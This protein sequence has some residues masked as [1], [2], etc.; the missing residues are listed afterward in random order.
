[1]PSWT[2]TEKLTP[3]QAE[4]LSKA[5]Q[6]EKTTNGSLEASAKPKKRNKYNAVKTEY[7]G[8]IYDSKGEANYAAELDMKQRAGLIQGWARQVEFVLAGGVKTK[9]D[10]I[11][12]HTDGTY[13]VVDFKGVLTQESKNKYKQVKAIHGIEVEI[14][15]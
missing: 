3:K 6:R 15:K 5:L 9:V 12:F 11:I 1:M 14:A 7:K 13:D 2:D 8:V 4:R 10:F